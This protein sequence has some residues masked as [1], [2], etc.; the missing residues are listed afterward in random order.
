MAFSNS[1]FALLRFSSTCAVLSLTDSIS[2]LVFETACF[3]SS[4]ASRAAFLASEMAFSNSVFVLSRFSSTCAVL[5]LTDSMSLVIF[6]TACSNSPCASFCAVLWDSVIAFSKSL[7]ALARSFSAFSWVSFLV[8]SIF[9]AMESDKLA[10]M[11]SIWWSATSIAS[12]LAVR[13]S[14]LASSINSPFIWVSEDSR[15]FA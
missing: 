4:C 6:E 12:D 3:N 1:V 15:S 2:L 10:V 11:V 5:S 13:A 14:F 9:V 8:D 7:F